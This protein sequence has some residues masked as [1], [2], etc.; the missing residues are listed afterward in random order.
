MMRPVVVLNA[1]YEPLTTVSLNRA[2]L[3]LV[4]ERAVVVE[5][6][7]GATIRSADRE[8]PVPKVVRLVKYVRVAYMHR[9]RAWSRR[10]VL[11][12][13]AALGCIYCGSK[14]NPTVEHIQ[15]ISRGGDPRGWL[16]TAVA[17]NTCNNTKGHQSLK[18]WGRPLRYKP[19]VVTERDTLVIAIAKAGVDPVAYGL[20]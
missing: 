5:A 17:C 8:I 7:E 20:T 9:P 13:D 1:S 4:K 18:E 16:N 14:K 6:V 10:G 19:R 2:V 15:P 11:E 12:R 3:F